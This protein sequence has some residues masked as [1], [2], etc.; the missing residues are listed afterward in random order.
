MK[1]LHRSAVNK[2]ASAKTFKN[3]SRHTKAANIAPGLAR[4]GIRL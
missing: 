1:P 2:N 3:H 4:G